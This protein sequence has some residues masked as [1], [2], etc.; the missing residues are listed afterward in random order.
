M[1]HILLIINPVSG[2]KQGQACMFEVL[3]KFSEYDVV[4]TIRLTKSRGHATEIAR[5]AALSGQYDA[6]F[7]CGGDGTLNEVIA[8]IVSVGGSLPVGYIPAGSTNDF[9]S[10]LG[11]PLELPASAES[12]CGVLLEGGGF[13]IDIGHFNSERY[14]SYI[15]SFGAFSASSYNAPQSAKNVLGHFAYVLEGV[16]D[17]F[18]I[19]PIHAVCTDAEGNVHEDDYVF[20]GVTNTYSVGGIVKLTEAMVNMN[21][22]LFEV[23]LVRMPHSPAELNRIVR[24]VMSSEFEN[25]PM[26]DFFRSPSLTFG[27]PEGTQWSLDGEQADGGGEVR[28]ENLTAAVTLLK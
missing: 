11:I 18:Q 14:F 19:K 27:M 16:K 20:G 4:P 2:K 24:A 21:D 13:P 9:A 28:I 6:V 15:A 7:C 3:E 5:E 26:I 22:G 23:L 25:N 17:F 12:A 1:K 8:G 10:G